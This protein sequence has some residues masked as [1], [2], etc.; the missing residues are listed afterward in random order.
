[1]K[2]ELK[3]KDLSKVFGLTSQRVNQ[4]LSE[5]NL[6]S[7]MNRGAKFIPT[8]SVRK[9]F[10]EKGYQYPQKTISFFNS[11]G[12]VGKTSILVGVALA[13][14]QH[15]AKVLVLDLDPQANASLALGEIDEDS[16]SMYEVVNG[17]YEIDEVILQVAD[18][19]SLVPSS[20][21][22]SFL[23]RTIQIK[24]K[25]LARVFKSHIEK[26]GKAYDLVLVDLPPSLNSVVSGA[27]AMSD[28]VVVPTTAGKF[29]F[30]GVGVAIDEIT[31]VS[32]EY[33]LKKPEISVLYNM[34]DARKKS[35]QEY[36]VRLID[37]YKD[38]LMRTFLGSSTTFENIRDGQLD[39]IL[40][41]NKSSEK[42]DIYDVAREI[43]EMNL[44][45]EEEQ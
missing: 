41:C 28:Q 18:N 29:S 39:F 45:T 22:M 38:I 43:L 3:T 37:S 10:E 6:P 30:N 14:A 26:V 42:E 17:E 11:K 23:D 1:M 12:G 7:Y 4:I 32:K 31:D 27:I 15:G 16:A 2:I 8:D 5:M 24:Q 19:I 13:A 44:L 34:Y 20:M 33:N 36:L 9:F 35:S 40:N 21:N 25:N